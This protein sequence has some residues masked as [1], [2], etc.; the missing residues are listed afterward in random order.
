MKHQQSAVYYLIKEKTEKPVQALMK[1][2]S[3]G[4]RIQ[5]SSWLPEKTPNVKYNNRDD[6]RWA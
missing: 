4:W 1:R 3:K 5:S 6:E 2:T